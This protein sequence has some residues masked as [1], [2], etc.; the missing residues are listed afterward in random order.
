MLIS[1]M[2]YLNIQFTKE[3]KEF[4]FKISFLEKI[5]EE[6][7]RSKMINENQ[8]QLN[9]QLQKSLKEKNTN[10][11]DQIY[12]LNYEMFEILSKNKLL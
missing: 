4:K 11:N 3:K 6:I 8:L 12:D 7:S 5:I 10:L 1:A 9:D 2:I